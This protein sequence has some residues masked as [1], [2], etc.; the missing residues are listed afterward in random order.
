MVAPHWVD[1]TTI[2]LGSTGKA[3]DRALA[4]KTCRLVSLLLW[5]GSDI[6]VQRLEGIETSEVTGVCSTADWLSTSEH[7]L[8][9]GTLC[10]VMS[11][12]LQGIYG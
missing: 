1:R 6:V 5:L 3:A 2:R 8:S 7:K 4:K 11:S 12:H 9:W 10:K